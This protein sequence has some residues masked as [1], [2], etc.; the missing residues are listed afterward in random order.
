[1]LRAVSAAGNGG[2]GTLGTTY[3]GTEGV[4]AVVGSDS[5]DVVGSDSGDVVSAA[6]KCFI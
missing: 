2:R 5:G 3:W 6:T 4:E 1:M